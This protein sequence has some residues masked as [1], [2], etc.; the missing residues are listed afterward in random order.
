MS[1][2]P[3]KRPNQR[4]LREVVRPSMYSPASQEAVVRDDSSESGPSSSD[5]RPNCSRL[6]AAF[7][8]ALLEADLMWSPAGRG[9]NQFAEAGFAPG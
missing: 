9:E 6:S 5:F 1:T 8:P 7:E 2:L 3:T 4:S